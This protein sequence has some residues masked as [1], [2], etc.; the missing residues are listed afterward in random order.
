MNCKE[1]NIVFLT[2]VYAKK[3]PHME[4]QEMFL[5]L[6]LCGYTID[7]CASCKGDCVGKS[8][9]V[10]Q[11]F[12]DNMRKVSLGIRCVDPF[13]T[14]VLGTLIPSNSVHVRFAE[15]KE[16]TPS[17]A[18]AGFDDGDAKEVLKRPIVWPKDNI[19]RVNVKG[20][21]GDIVGSA[22][23]VDRM[24]VRS[25]IGVRITSTAR[26]RTL[27][28]SGAVLLTDFRGASVQGGVCGK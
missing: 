4:V 19:S 10:C 13:E 6:A 3:P 15:V 8:R 7:G 1:M 12:S 18:F 2:V 24:P 23:L 9:G 28:V 17:Q 5:N 21:Y 25:S 27:N 22:I 20:E 11:M 26:S 16:G 14:H